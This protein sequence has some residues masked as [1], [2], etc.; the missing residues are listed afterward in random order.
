[1][2]ILEKR[3]LEESDIKKTQSLKESANIIHQTIEDWILSKWSIKEIPQ[4]FSEIPEWYTNNVAHRWNYTEEEMDETIEDWTRKL[5]HLDI[6]IWK[7]CRLRCPHCFK[8][9]NELQNLTNK[10]ELSLD[11][12]KNVIIKFKEL[13]LK[14]IKVCWAWEP[15]DNPDFLPFLRFLHENNIWVSVFTKWY[16]IWNDEL[17]KE[18][19]GKYWINNSK[20]LCKELKRLDVSILLSL[21]SFDPEI[22]KRYSW[23]TKW[24]MSWTYIESRDK[25]LVNLINAWLN[26]FVPW[27]PT[28]L[29]VIMAPMKPENLKEIP[30][31][32]EWARM[33][34][35]YPLWCP[36]NNAWRWKDENERVSE[37]D[38]NYEEDLVNLYAE[39]YIWNIEHWIT[40]LEKVE[41][42]GISLYP[43]CHPC[44]Q[45][46]AWWYLDL[47]W[48]LRSCP[49]HDTE[50]EWLKI[51]W[52]IIDENDIKEM[53]KRSAN[54]NRKWFN[55]HCIARD[56]ISLSK[57][58]YNRIMNKIKAQFAE[59]NKDLLLEKN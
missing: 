58:F 12:L 53:W 13:W 33:R 8:R 44:T 51:S 23:A 18:N 9:N 39:I 42:D 5:L 14:S 46:R 45:S 10:K 40:T 52:N 54:Y 32:Y 50:I 21:N 34:N 36:A 47:Y 11:D 41:K 22:Q 30:E 2:T 15:F 24:P 59:K 35:I 55:Q 17:V 20:E 56:W 25:A 29:A 19:F 31:I 28:R 57:D 1:M 49:W 6:D 48:V 7:K 38:P 3:E 37:V 4:M 43:W 27:E 26:D 16:V